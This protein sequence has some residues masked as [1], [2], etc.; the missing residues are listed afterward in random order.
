M[1]K[2]PEDQRDTVEKELAGISEKAGGLM[3]QAF[4]DSA[5]QLYGELRNRAKSENDLIYYVIGTFFQMNLA[6]RLLKFDTVRERAIELIAIFE[7]EEQARKIEPEMELNKYENLKY[8]MCACAYEVL[9]EATGDL[10]GYNSEGM[11]ECLT[12]GIDVCRRIGKLSC[13]GCFREYACDIHRAAD[14]YELARYHCNQV[15]KQEQEFSD[16][17][18]RRWLATLKL[19]TLDLYEGEHEAARQRI[20]RAWELAKS[21]GVNDPLG[22]GLALAFELRT[23]DLLE[24]KPL[25]ER[26]EETL[27]KLPPR[28][29]CPEYDLDVDCLKSLELA[30]NQEWQAAEKC[31]VPWVRSLKQAGATTKWLEVGIRLVS[32][33]RLQGDLEGAKRIAAPIE[34]AATKSNDWQSVRRISQVLD[35]SVDITPLGTIRRNS[36][37]LTPEATQSAVTQ[38]AVQEDQGTGVEVQEKDENETPPGYYP[39]SKETPLYGWLENFAHRLE[40]ARDEAGVEAD[41]E[42]FRIELIDSENRDWSHPEDIGRAIHFMVYLVTPGCDYRRV[43]TWANKLVSGYQETGYLISLLARLGMSINAA[44]RFDQFSKL[45]FSSMVEELPPTVIGTERLDQLVR[46]SLQ[47]DSGSVN[48]NFRA[49]EVFEYASNLGEAERC[50]ARAFKLD[51]KRDDAALALARIYTNTDRNA[52][53]HYVL[54]LCIREGGDSPEL[55]FEAAMRAHAMSMHELQVSYLKTLLERF[56][57]SPWCYYYLA[58]GLLE[59]KKP[60][61]ALEAIQKEVEEFKGVGVHIDAIR[62]EGEAMLQHQDA[63]ARAVEA[64]LSRSL[65]SSDA[66]TLGGIASALDRLWRASKQLPNHRELQSRVETRLLQCGVASEAYFQQLRQEEKPRDLFLFHVNLLQP[67]DADWNEFPGCLPE[68][69]DWTSYLA[70]WGVLAETADEAEKIA[71]EIQRQ[72]YDVIEPEVMEI[73]PDEDPLHDRPGIAFQGYRTSGDDFLDDEDSDELE[74]DELF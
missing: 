16:R 1:A 55:F 58:I 68:Q 42:D 35:P 56:E 2:K 6:Q 26:I 19:A 18:D 28:D 13:I 44:E 31:L 21:P 5:Y 63:A 24:G 48:N 72:C 53:A 37:I 14:D 60:E 3:E 17:G 10:E 51:R 49:G 70:H 71:L 52:D 30:M 29:E 9:A 40:G 43:W 27:R 73:I 45:D 66:L 7:N 50:Y 23:L 11:Q 8:A 22:S 39:I 59:L 47:L 46:K 33:K 65:A 69:E 32:I 62:A 41:I 57:A 25:E 74:D 4:C 36:R 34:E 12:G 15:L 54:D 38:S 67:L 20:E 64:G 61:E